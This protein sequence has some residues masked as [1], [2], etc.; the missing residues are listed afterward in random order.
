MNVTA[1]I[2]MVRHLQMGDI[3][4]SLYAALDVPATLLVIGTYLTMV[5]NKEKVRKVLDDFQEI[6]DK[7][8]DG[9]LHH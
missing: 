1:T 3:E 8:N 2:Y 9:I 5:Y 7:C 6:F 4:N